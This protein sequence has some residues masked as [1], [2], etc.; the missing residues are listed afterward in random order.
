MYLRKLSANRSGFH[1]IKFKDGLNFIVGKR[2]NPEEKDLKNTYNGVGKSLAIEL[3]HF[4]L[5]SKKIDV[6]EENLE[7]WIFTLEFEIDSEEYIVS[8]NCSEQ[9]NV[10]LNGKKI[11]V[12]KYT[13]LL[14][15]KVF[16]FEEDN[17]I[18]YLTFRSLISRFIRRS[19]SSYTK[20]DKY[21][22]KE[23]DYAKL[24]NNAYL[25]GLDIDLI[26]TKM[27]L[28]KSIDELEKNKK[29]VE[30]DP[31]L[32]EY[33]IGNDD[34]D[35]EIIDLKEEVKELEKKAR[36][37]KVAENY[38]EIQQEADRLSYHI[39]ELKNKGTLIENSIRKIEKSLSLKPEIEL[40]MILE[41]YG[42]ARLLF[43]D[44]VKKTLSEVTEFHNKLLLSRNERL[45]RQKKSFEK[46]KEE[47]QE[48]IIEKGNELDKKMKYLGGYGALEEYNALHDK[49]SS[50]RNNLEKVMD[51]KN[52]LETYDDRSAQAKIDIEQQ[53]LETS[54]YL[55]EHK[56]ML[57]DIMGTFRSYSKAF[58]K[59]KASGLDIKINDGLNQIRF[60]INAKITGDSSDGISEV[61]IFCFD[62]TLLKLKNHNVNFIF[63]DSRLFSNMDPRQR[64]SLLKIVKQ[65]AKD[66]KIQYITSINE[67][68]ISTIRDVTN[69]EEYLYYKKLIDMNTILTLTD[70]S[71]EDKLLG[72]TIDL[73]YDK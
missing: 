57:E 58:Y 20:Y 23:T 54:K 14:L 30:K 26:E 53:K 4:C 31:I 68:M 69:E 63:H 12:G 52:L 16:G 50:L 43:E 28:K 45:E 1:T 15:E 37:F 33:F 67:D 21:Q 65:E 36:E 55:K 13:K 59:N 44:K 38:R 70:K 24:L 56:E 48:R 60:E 46:E 61:C 17:K 27:I 64:L 35:F 34:L 51:Y 25:L 8:R 22:D 39:R 18:K 72:M 71:D 40:D 2:E 5:G 19:K 47:I 9:N 10:I 42:E 73:P 29:I 62:M 11:S 49:L 3:I 6:F 66:E 7:G 32:K 41:M